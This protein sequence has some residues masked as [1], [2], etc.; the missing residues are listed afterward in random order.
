MSDTLQAVLCL[1]FQ[2][3][4]HVGSGKGKGH[5]I[6]E[7]CLKDNYGLPYVSGKQLKG[8]LRHAV[9]RAEKWGWYRDINLPIKNDSD[10]A[11][12]ESLLFGS[13]SQEEGRFETSSG[14]LFVDNATL[15]KE[16]YDFLKASDQASLR[17]YLYQPLYST[18]IDANTGSAVNMSLR[19]IEVTMP[20]TLYAELSLKITAFDEDLASQQQA[21]LES[22]PWDI[23][24][25]ALPLVDAV[26]AHRSRG[27]G[28]SVLSLVTQ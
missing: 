28:E 17:Q 3:F 25:K 4:W 15:A 9:R 20:V 13:A 21:M 27:L 11:S 7:E 2:G 19:G 1:E 26:G 23:I 24:E 14:M 6:D 5:Y 16:E 22:S 10:A 8:L 12:I 18:R